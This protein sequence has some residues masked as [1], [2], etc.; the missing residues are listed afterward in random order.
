MTNFTRRLQ[1]MGSGGSIIVVPDEP[2][3]GVRMYLSPVGGTYSSGGSMQVQIRID[4]GAMEVNAYQ[5]NVSYP[6]GLMSF[7]GTTTTGS[8]FTTVILNTESGGMVRL[9]AAIMAGT[10][11]GDQLLGTMTFT[12]SAAGTA[13]L[14]YETG[15]GV[16]RASDST[17]AAN[18]FDGV[19]YTI[20]AG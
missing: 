8:P 14:A 15:S 17:A 7:I 9:S 1:R 11:S 6:A 2:A 18:Q 12:A 5:A 13:S 20:T 4:S 19:N 16:A 10:T 3:E